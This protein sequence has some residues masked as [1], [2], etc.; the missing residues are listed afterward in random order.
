MNDP[1]YKADLID[2]PNSALAEMGIRVSE[3]TKL[4]VTETE[5]IF[6]IQR[7]AGDIVRILLPV[8]L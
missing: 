6:A 7:V 5:S 2:N 4:V 8:T 1:D 3:K